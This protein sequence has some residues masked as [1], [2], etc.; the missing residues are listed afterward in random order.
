MGQNIHEYKMF[1]LAFNYFGGCFLKK[2][3]TNLHHTVSFVLVQKTT[4]CIC[5][6]SSS[7]VID[8]SL[9]IIIY[10]WMKRLQNSIFLPQLDLCA[11]LGVFQCLRGCKSGC[12]RGRSRWDFP[13][14][15]DHSWTWVVW[16]LDARWPIVS[17]IVQEVCPVVVHQPR[18]EKGSSNIV[19]PTSFRENFRKATSLFRAI[20][21]TKD[22]FSLNSA[23]HTVWKPFMSF[24]RFLSIGSR[25]VSHNCSFFCS[26][27]SIVT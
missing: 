25:A 8:S 17:C 1:I 12:Q 19:I 13:C 26:C 27:S 10:Q 2:I 6:I 3:R 24:F 15:L 5:Q 18:R 22:S 14:H 20:L 9:V 11:L 16:V 7:F 4:L 21:P 23:S